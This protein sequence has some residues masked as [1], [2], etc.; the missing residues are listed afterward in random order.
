MSR[1][2]QEV[3]SLLYMYEYL[4]RT[5]VLNTY[6]YTPS[7]KKLFL[8]LRGGGGAMKNQGSLIIKQ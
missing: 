1:V 6:S 5:L 7:G 4:I 8:V 3:M 2:S